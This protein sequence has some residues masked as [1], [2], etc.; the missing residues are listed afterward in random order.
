MTTPTA[1]AVR[2]AA[3]TDEQV[4]RFAALAEVAGGFAFVRIT[5]L[6]LAALCR[7]I[8]ADRATLAAM[9]GPDSPIQLTIERLA[10]TTKE[11]NAYRNI[12]TECEGS[13]CD[14]P[15]KAHRAFSH[16]VQADQECAALQEENTAL[17]DA[18]DRL[19]RIE[20]EL[21]A[22]LAEPP[23]AIPRKP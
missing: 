16:H 10:E 1:P 4:A 3:A 21:R 11:R 15:E 8:D 9:T 12:F 13:E 19:A 17:H 18:N 2:P 7:R 20:A 14:T 5:A 6:D 22:L 23:L